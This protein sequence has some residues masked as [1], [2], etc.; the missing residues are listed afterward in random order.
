MEVSTVSPVITK[1]ADGFLRN[2]AVGLE[3]AGCTV[4]FMM[5]VTSRLSVQDSVCSFDDW[6]DWGDWDVANCRDPVGDRADDCIVTTDDSPTESETV[7]PARLPR[8]P[9]LPILQSR[10]TT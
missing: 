4:R 10:F 2:A 7:I 1:G 3:Y 8:F 5:L 6:G 9:R